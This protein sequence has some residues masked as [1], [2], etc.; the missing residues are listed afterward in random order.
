MVVFSLEC[1]R[2]LPVE[3]NDW[4]VGCSEVLDLPRAMLEVLARRGR[5]GAGYITSCVCPPKTI[6]VF[7]VLFMFVFTL[8]RMTL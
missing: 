7:F 5:R 3:Q 6:D 2:I 4:Q 8:L 1:T